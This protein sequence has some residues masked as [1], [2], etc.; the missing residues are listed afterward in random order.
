M[1]LGPGRIPLQQHGILCAT[2][3]F[4]LA[5]LLAQN[6]NELFKSHA[7]RM[8]RGVYRMTKREKLNLAGLALGIT[9]TLAWIGLMGVALSQAI[10]WLL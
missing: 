3:A 10:S 8:P 1:E 9:A 5:E 7:L 4:F 6:P 2:V